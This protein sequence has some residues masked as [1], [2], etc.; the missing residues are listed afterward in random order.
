MNLTQRFQSKTLRKTEVKS[1]CILPTECINILKINS[2]SFPNRNNRL[3]FVA[4]SWYISCEVVT[5]FIKI[6]T[7]LLKVLLGNASINALDTL[8]ELQSSSDFYVVFATQQSK[9]C[10]FYVVLAS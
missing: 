8:D 3:G 4:E 5:E 9:S 2:D 1:F 6:V 10:V 7:P